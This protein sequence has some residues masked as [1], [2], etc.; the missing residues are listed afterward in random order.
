MATQKD[1][2]EKSQSTVFGT[3]ARIIRTADVTPRMRRIT[4]GG[5]GLDPLLVGTRLPADAIKLYLPPPGKAGFKPEFSVMPSDENPFSI[6]AYTIRRF[7][8]VALELDIDIVL[9]GDSPGSVWARSVQPGDQI[10]FVGPR[11]DYLGIEGVDWLL[12][13]GDETAQPAISAIVESLPS[14]TQ[15]HIFL[16]VSN[17]FDELPFQ[18]NA[19][20]SVTWLHRGDV[21][22]GKSDLLEQAIRRF[23]WQDGVPYVW[24]AGETGI[25]RSIRHYLRKERKLDK[26]LLHISGYWRYGLNNR[27][28]DLKTV[29]EYQAAL[30]AGKTIDDHHDVD[31]VE[32]ELP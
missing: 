7:D 6:R 5:E 28:F 25:V 17:Q 12:L 4:L 18:T 3:L 13:A 9:H 24:V 21:A 11:H 29:Q 19:D 32:L 27:E 31:Q 1:M 14:G 23:E 30:A 10:G 22:S 20:I 8:P 2:R 16:E 26:E 15:A